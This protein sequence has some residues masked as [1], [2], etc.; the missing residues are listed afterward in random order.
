MN[1]G[2]FSCQANVSTIL[3]FL[4]L[5]NRF[6]TFFLTQ[7][8]FVVVL[9][10]TCEGSI[11]IINTLCRVSTRIS[12][13]HTN[14]FE[15]KKTSEAELTRKSFHAQEEYILV[16]CCLYVGFIYLHVYTSIPTMLRCTTTYTFLTAV[17]AFESTGALAFLVRSF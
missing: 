13:T 14:C 2:F 15:R 3:I 4:D 9:T 7:H 6:V 5:F 8:S 1:D 12:F 10:F 11:T 16:L 17:I